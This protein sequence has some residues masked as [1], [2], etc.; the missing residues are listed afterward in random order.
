M[1]LEID[2]T[3]E[4]SR[5]LVQEA[6]GQKVFQSASEVGCLQANMPA[7][8]NSGCGAYKPKRQ[9]GITSLQQVPESELMSNS[10]SKNT[11]GETAFSA[12]HRVNVVMGVGGRDIIFLRPHTILQ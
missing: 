1:F 12:C 3:R 10:D 6:V 8:N 2:P 4:F 7:E 9:Q 11:V 5:A